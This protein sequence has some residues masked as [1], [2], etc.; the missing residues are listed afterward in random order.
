MT[1][2]NDES[3]WTRKAVPELRIVTQELWDAA[4]ARKKTLDRTKPGL[5]N[6]TR[7]QYLLSGL[8]KCG[9]CHGGYSK[10][11]TTH[12]GCSTARN[13]GESVCSNRKTIRRDILEDTVLS[14]LQTHLMR[15][16]LLQVFCEEY[17]RH[18]NTLHAA[19]NAKLKRYHSK[20][21]ALAKERD[22]IIQAIKDGIPAN[23]VKDDL[24]RVTAK[25]EEIEN[26]LKSHESQ[27][28][29]LLHPSM[30]KRY[31][32]EIKALRQSLNNKESRNEASQHLRGLIEKI[33]LTPRANQDDLSIDLYG[34]LAEI[35]TIATEDKAMKKGETIAK[36]L[37]TM[38][39]NDN[40]Y[41]E[42]STNIIELVAGTGFEPVTFGL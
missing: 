20:L 33:V 6:K 5:W 3:E 17:T 21:S 10:I 39:A 29:P 40:D 37:R 31:Q 8:L 11:N 35:L 2:I 25:R 34:D 26:L 36:R 14:A 23:M 42:P 16:D 15:D 32:Q 41:S 1:R 22:N 24:F 7:P 12:Y 18:M 27:P 19:Q 13:K 9:C 28:K 30:A 38:I 4:Q